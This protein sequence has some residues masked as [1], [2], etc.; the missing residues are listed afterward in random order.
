[1]L[2]G[3]TRLDNGVIRQDRIFEQQKQYDHQYVD[4]RYNSYGD[5]SKRMSYLRLGFLLGTIGF[6]PNSILDVGYG[7]GDFLSVC[8][9]TIKDCYGND[10]SGYPLP[11]RCYF[12]DDITDRYFDVI[13][14]FD[15]LEHFDDPTIIEEL[16]CS[17]I[18]IS[19]PWCHW[20]GDQDDQWFA[21]WKHRRP[22][23]HLWHFN[24]LS[25]VKFFAECGY[26]LVSLCSIEDIIRK[27]ETPLPNILT[28]IFKKN[29]SKNQRDR[30]TATIHN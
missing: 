27:P 21:N 1:M 20:R 28:G 9:D 24:N 6:L 25:L 29:E 4:A 15:V 3:Y 10:I 17:Y 5:L 30:A 11:D 16:D 19:V 18:M 7:N 12:I 13:T 26:S 22:D 14:F 2:E 23:E 8:S